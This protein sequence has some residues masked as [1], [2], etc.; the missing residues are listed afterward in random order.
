VRF[1]LAVLLA[2]A[3]CNQSPEIT[4][5]GLDATANVVDALTF[6][7]CTQVCVR[8]SDCATAYPDD[9]ICPPGFAC[10]RTFSCGDAGMP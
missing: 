7:R 4:D 3:G 8:P 1:A 5:G 6:E 2:L 9:E 10:S